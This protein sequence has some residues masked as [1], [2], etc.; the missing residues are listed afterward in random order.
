MYPFRLIKYISLVLIFLSVQL[1]A[2]HPVINEVQYANKT[3]LYDCDGETP[4]WIEVYN[5]TQEAINLK[6]YQLNDEVDSESAWSFPDTVLAAQSYLLAYASG[7][8]INSGTEIHLPFKLG[9]L[10]DS[11]F[12]FSPEHELIDVFFTKCVPPDKSLGRQTDGVGETFILSPTPGYS[13][14]SAKIHSINYHKDSLW[15]SLESGFFN[16]DTTVKAMNLIERN[17]IRYTFDA[18]EVDWDSE[19]YKTPLELKNINGTL[20]RFANFKESIFQPG[21]EI[22]KANVL[23]IQAFSEG[24]P[25]SRELIETYFIEEHFPT[26]YQAVPIV[27]LVTDKKNLFDDE[28]GIYV[29]GNYNNYL[30]RGDSWERPIHIEVFDSA[31]NSI[32]KQHAGARMHGGF[33]RWF[34]QKSFRLYARNRYGKDHFVNPGFKQKPE[35]AIFKKLLLRN[36]QIWSGVMFTD[37]MCNHLVDNLNIDYSAS[38]SV[39]VYLNGEYWGI[40]SLR[41]FFDENYVAGNCNIE[42]PELDVT[43]SMEGI[44][45]LNDYLLNN[46]VDDENFLNGLNEIIDVESVIDYYVAQFYLANQDYIRNSKFWK[47]KNEDTKWRPF[48]FDLDF[49][50]PISRW[51]ELFTEFLSPI[52]HVKKYPASRTKT[53]STLFENKAFRN[54]FY[55]RFIQILDAEFASEKVLDLIEQYSALYAPLVNDHTYRWGI[56]QDI[57]SWNESLEKLR[58]YAMLRP[59]KLNELFKE[60][61]GNPF[62]IY[63]NPSNGKFQIEFYNKTENVQICVYSP[64]GIKIDEKTV[65]G[66]NQSISLN[67]PVGIYIL[68]ILQNDIWYTDKILIK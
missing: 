64:Q 49:S 39:V 7:R 45:E 22:S 12:L 20:N 28:I 55:S 23:R 37:E 36:V 15:L 8:T 4:D 10:K 5:P 60:F 24:C 56:P 26:W 9:Q 54:Q 29:S 31:F 32:I 38:E 13:N 27:S 17:E 19:L 51:D 2:Q 48:F 21:K 63:P 41:E 65:A 35:I 62:D 59:V 53:L 33:S 47:E 16:S 46:S 42:N 52:S 61:F 34:D 25:A 1:Q 18:D 43:S 30:K 6:G 58:T 57:L 66:T 67:L 14:E 3:T 50:F 44:Q 11:V 40:Y 68:R